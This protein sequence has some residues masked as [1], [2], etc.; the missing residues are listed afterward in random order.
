MNEFRKFPFSEARD[1]LYQ[2]DLMLFYHDDWFGNFTRG[3]ICGLPLDDEFVGE[4]SYRCCRFGQW[5]YSGMD[6]T[7]KQTTIMQ[8][9]ELIHRNMH[10]AFRQFYQKWREDPQ[11][12]KGLYDE[13]LVKR[14][15][16]KLSVNT[17]QFMI[18]DHLLQT[19]PL[20]KTF[21]RTK[22][23]STLER[24]RKRIEETGE[25]CAVAMADI[26][27]FKQVN[28]C[29]GHAVGDMVLVQT[30]ALIRN[31]LRPMDLVFRYGG[32]EFLLYLPGVDQK[33]A[34]TALNRIREKVASNAIL[35]GEDQ[36]IR[37]TISFGAARLDTSREIAAS[38]AMADEALY[39]AKHN[40]R[41]RVEWREE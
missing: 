36:T 8:D 17:L 40:G 24:E 32:E 1:V 34:L 39:L 12:A 5:I 4:A 28:D 35:I 14:T 7:V 3:I 29:H 27:H 33:S 16:F 2:L 18:Y 13:A 11:Q 10:L 6:S 19:D 9:I 20:T 23:L 31:M 37:I 38:V 26:D 41:N 30:A 15:A 25:S 22:L 21:N